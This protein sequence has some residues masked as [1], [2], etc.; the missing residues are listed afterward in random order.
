MEW[1]ILLY[2]LTLL[3]SVAISIAVVEIFFLIYN[4]TSPDHVFKGLS[5]LMGWSFL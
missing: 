3:G 1:S 4:M 5:Y 2:V